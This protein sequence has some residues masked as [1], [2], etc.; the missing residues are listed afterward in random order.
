MERQQAYDFLREMFPNKSFSLQD[1]LWFHKSEGDLMEPEC[2]IGVHGIS[3]QDGGGIVSGTGKTWNDA[4]KAM[5][6][7]LFQYGEA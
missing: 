2:R 1:T 7:D 5:F 4:I 3:L 6:K